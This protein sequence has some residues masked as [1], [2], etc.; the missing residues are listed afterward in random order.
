M[1]AE[2][3]SANIASYLPAMA[4][5]YPDRAAVAFPRNGRYDSW[6]FSQLNRTAD[7]YARA[8]SDA[9]AKRGQKALLMVKPGPEFVAATFAVFKMGVRP[10]L[11]D[12]GMGLKGMLRCVR[13]IAP[14]LFLGIPL[15][16][17]LRLVF[18]RD[19]AS[20]SLSFVINGTFP[21][22]PSLERIAS[23]SSAS[24]PV[25]DVA[26]DEPAAI[27]FT[28][29]STG[30]A[31][32]VVYEHGMFQAQ[33]QELLAL[34]DF[35]PDDVDMPGFP[36]FA[37]FDTAMAM[38]SVIPEL[39]PSRPA[40]CD[41]ARLAAAIQEYGVTTC[42][43][44]PAIW[45]RVGRH[46]RDHGIKL[47]SLKRVITF[48]APISVDL[49]RMWRQVLPESGDVYT[50]YGATEALPVSM[51]SGS[52]ILAETAALAAE[53]AGTCVGRPAPGIDLRIVRI[54]DEPIVTWTDDLQ[55][56]AGEIGEVAVRGAVVTREYAGL[57]EATRASK[58]YSTDGGVWH[59]M[60]DVG[61]LDE[62][63][64][65]WFCGRKAHRVQT[66]EG[67]LFSVQPE[68]MADTHEAVFR[69]A[70][71]GIGAPGTQEPVLV[72]EPE[73]GRFPRDRAE[74]DRLAGEILDRY[75]VHPDFHVIDR[76]L[77]HRGFPVDPRHNAKIHREDLAAWA[78]RQEKARG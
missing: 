76:V 75:S 69:S 46:C 41:P 44:S 61:Y 29:G 35:R 12:P 18:R 49:I 74:A 9:G 60:G 53:G 7:A 50:P 21:G 2:V 16:H 51:I 1:T 10:V 55:V 15:A 65:L 32:G 58:I 71:V 27:L 30:P 5:R 52:E 17:A 11:I 38:T 23:I 70:L 34:F 33:V 14:D 36:L 66:V 67:T 8:L 42:Q 62:E 77:F 48:G 43:G 56:P 4:R 20:V 25:A 19:F 24:F 47:P 57:P 22:T 68:G 40:T 39:N 54:S 45:N 59:R 72:V 73:P 3:T 37:L 63:G 28:S 13:H 64:R 31:K 26:D 6:S 78:A